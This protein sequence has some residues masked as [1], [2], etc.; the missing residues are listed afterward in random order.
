M[1]H[2]HERLLLLLLLLGGSGVGVGQY[3]VVDNDCRGGASVGEG[4]KAGGRN[5][6]C[7]PAGAGPGL[8]HESSLVTDKIGR[9]REELREVSLGD[10]AVPT[11]V[12][13]T[14]DEQYVLWAS[15]HKIVM[16]KCTEATNV[17]TVW[18][19]V[20]NNN[21]ALLRVAEG[22]VEAAS[23]TA[24]AFV[25]F[26]N[27]AGLQFADIDFTTPRL[28]VKGHKDLDGDTTIASL[29]VEKVVGRNQY[30]VT[31]F[32]QGAVGRVQLTVDYQAPD[33]LAV[34]GE[35]MDT[36]PPFDTLRM[37][38]TYHWA[39]TQDCV[40]GVPTSTATEDGRFA[41]AGAALATWTLPQT[42]AGRRS[43][44]QTDVASSL[45]MGE[46]D[47][48]D[49]VFVAFTHGHYLYK[50]ELSRRDRTL[51][52]GVVV[53]STFVVADD[54][55]GVWD[56]SDQSAWT[57]ET[58]QGLIHGVAVSA[59]GQKVVTAEARSV[60]HIN[61][62]DQRNRIT[63]R[64]TAQHD[65]ATK[66]RF[67]SQ[68][69]ACTP[70]FS[71]GAAGAT[72]PDA[73]ARKAEVGE[74]GLATALD[75]LD[76]WARVFWDPS[77]RVVTRA[78][79]SAGVDD[80]NDAS[81]REKVWKVRAKQF[82]HP[83]RR[84]A[85]G[86]TVLQDPTDETKDRRVLFENGVR[87][88]ATALPLAVDLQT[89]GAYADEVTGRFEAD[90]VEGMITK[91]KE[92]TGLLTVHGVQQVL[93]GCNLQ[94]AGGGGN[95][96]VAA[97]RTFA[98]FAVET[99]IPNLRTLAN[100][101]S[102]DY[103]DPSK[104]YSSV[105]SSLKALTGR[106][107]STLGGAKN[108]QANGIEYCMRYSVQLA[109]VRKTDSKG[110][111]FL[112]S[113]FPF[114]DLVLNKNAVASKFFTLD[115][116]KQCTDMFGQDDIVAFVHDYLD[117][118]LA[119]QTF[120]TVRTAYGNFVNWFDNPTTHANVAGMFNAGSLTK[121]G[122]TELKRWTEF[123]GTETRCWEKINVKK[124]ATVSSRASDMF[125]TNFFATTAYTTAM[126]YL[127]QTTYST[128][129]WTKVWDPSN[130]AA[131]GPM[132]CCESDWVTQGKMQA[133]LTLLL[134]PAS[135]LDDS[136]NEF[137][138]FHEGARVVWYSSDAAYAQKLER[139]LEDLYPKSLH[140]L[141]GRWMG[142]K[143][144]R[145]RHPQLMSAN[146]KFKA[147]FSSTHPPLV[148][149]QQDPSGY[150]DPNELEADEGFRA[151]DI[152]RKADRDNLLLQNGCFGN[153][154]F[155]SPHPPRRRGYRST[156]ASDGA[157]RR[158]PANI[159]GGSALSVAQGCVDPSRSPLRDDR[160]T[161]ESGGWEW[162]HR[163][164][165][166]IEGSTADVKANLVVG[167]FHANTEMITY[168]AVFPKVVDWLDESALPAL[169]VGRRE[170]AYKHLA[171]AANRAA[172][173]GAGVGAK[174]VDLNTDIGDDGSGH[175]PILPSNMEYNIEVVLDGVP[176]RAGTWNVDLFKWDRPSQFLNAVAYL[177]ADIYDMASVVANATSALGGGGGGGGGSAPGRAAR[178]LAAPADVDDA[179]AAAVVLGMP[180]A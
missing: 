25:V 163:I 177:A 22:W 164:A 19:G 50:L 93:P 70:V 75:R 161:S 125:R 160:Q 38:G 47:D 59:R 145:S 168:E 30:I 135:D 130:G 34:V 139:G 46:A 88:A 176:V 12:A 69:H 61:D 136:L 172:L 156:T 76:A 53:A 40:V 98:D 27:N 173:D 180:G 106:I 73:Y 108:Q 167:T 43:Q 82:L 152:Q 119:H 113:F 111:F 100:P 36:T 117:N 72:Q 126:T 116:V 134:C 52:Y 66:V 32:V 10:I 162:L 24:H 6:V 90:C 147:V 97:S 86:R 58:A 84:G 91:M 107:G 41:C 17:Q 23:E 13:T 44:V 28:N 83:Y 157:A 103:A 33:T 141:T 79:G 29:A 102:I 112:G 20:E 179:D 127:K 165:Q 63:A 150:T 115:A 155:A 9:E 94:I 49:R 120:A 7:L 151:G 178:T 85:A 104:D 1:A 8:L 15:G 16:Q 42:P 71:Y 123:G 35:R 14:E 174:R 37:D 154:R 55:N 110:G 92:R 105:R 140:S 128:E 148:M 56:E 132:Y 48:A 131:T 4:G 129:E 81:F 68:K 5:L 64:L 60:A 89:L 149:W 143:I 26:R 122:S 114:L 11:R 57:A 169:S 96:F 2:G 62:E 21:I 65:A 51:Q 159:M 74:N 121:K 45:A 166:S 78:C 137:A 77:N 158:T 54:P 144:T 142:R 118:T 109:T 133:I 153:V 39:N 175:G 95:L 146:P 138:R 18:D 87:G 124:S 101:V 170:E 67:H 80:V 31:Y 3:C 171:R 99:L